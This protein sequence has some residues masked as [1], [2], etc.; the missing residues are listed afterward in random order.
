MHIP[1]RTSVAL[2]ALALSACAAGP[3]PRLNSP[4]A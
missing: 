4:H 2:I 1:V 3:P